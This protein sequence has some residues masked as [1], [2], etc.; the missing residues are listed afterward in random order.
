ME[1]RSLD[2]SVRVDAGILNERVDLAGELLA[3]REQLR[4]VRAQPGGTSRTSSIG[5]LAW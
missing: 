3:A 1:P 2:T 5:H 4:A